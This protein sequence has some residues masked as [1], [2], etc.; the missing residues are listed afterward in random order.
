MTGK[1]LKVMIVG[2]GTGGLCLAQGLKLNNVSVELFERDYSPTD[3]LQ[4][5][6]L[7][8]DTAGGKALRSCLPGPLFENLVGS[9]AKPSQRV[10]F[11]DHRMNRLL[12]IDFPQSE[13]KGIDTEL[14]VSRIALRRILLEGLGPFIHFGKKFVAFEDAPDGA[15]TA[16]FEDGSTATGDVLIGA[17]G[18]GSH[19][20]AQLLPD[21]RRAETGILA[22]SGKFHL[23]NDAREATPREIFRG[24]TLILGPKGCFLFTSAVE[25]GERAHNAYKASIDHDKVTVEPGDHSYLSYDRD[26]YVM[27]GF[28]ARREKFGLPENLE[29][30]DGKKFKEAVAALMHDWHPALRSLVHRA[31]CS[32]INAFP[33]KTSIPIPP[34]KTRNVTLLGDALHNM[35]PFRGIGANTALR[36]A[37]AL[38]R[39]LVRVDRGEDEL[40][41]ALGAYE[42]DMIEYGFRAVRTSLKEMERLHSEGILARAFMKIF[43]RTL[44]LI[45]PLKVAFHRLGK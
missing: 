15:V 44:D 24:P 35:T 27:W 11:L 28:S 4:G 42:R 9:S 17:D 3:R 19:L 12:A 16:R 14:P 22:I 38:H 32:T 31:E 1:P 29:A 33:V 25:Y 5:Y 30:V 20:R 8:I 13:R 45:P 2:A 39:A 18:A 37:A 7:S 36:D 6:R 10:A 34:W 26:E 40:I 21:A 23:S 43:F 41:P